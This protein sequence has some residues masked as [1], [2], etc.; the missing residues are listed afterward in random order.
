SY[1]GF[2]VVPGAGIIRWG[3]A[4]VKNFG[5]E[6]A[7]A[8]VKDRKDNGLFKDLPDLASRISTKAFNKK[9]LDSMIKSGALDI[10]GDRSTLIANMDQILGFNKRV[11]KQQ[12]QN[13]IS[14]FDLS[15]QMAT[16]K[17]TL[18]EVPP[19][20]QAQLLAEEKELLGLYVSNHPAEVFTEEM[21]KYATP[22]KKVAKQEDG[23]VIKVVGVITGV[24]KI[25]TKKKQE[26]MAF[27]KIED[28]SGF[29]ELVV[30]PKTFTKVRHLLEE[31]NFV[32]VMGKVSARERG[33]DT[34]YSILVDEIISFKDSQVDQVG[35]MLK[36]GSWNEKGFEDP[37]ETDEEFDQQKQGVS[38]VMPTKPDHEMIDRL[39]AIFK[40]APGFEPVYLVVE[41]GGKKRRV[42]T[43][44]A[45]EKTHSVIEAIEKIVGNG[46]VL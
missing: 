46:G 25:L 45:I 18:L 31:S 27:V 14:M 2:S 38:I 30:F 19:L 37:E 22:C 12:E 41:S 10:F 24:K 6:A 15:P 16:S 1:P 35:Y 28:K 13:Q 11:M 44:F 5:E 21:E 36:N 42:S 43:E 33:E 20:P 4:A 8:I 17:L 39:R 26:P 7:K 23:A 3:L 34:E 40:G 9:S 32:V 29:T